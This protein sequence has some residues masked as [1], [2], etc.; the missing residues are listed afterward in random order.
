MMTTGIIAFIG[1]LLVY[2][3]YLVLADSDDFG[4]KRLAKA[5]PAQD[6][7]GELK[8]EQSVSISDDLTAYN[9]CVSIGVDKTGLYL[10]IAGTWDMKDQGRPPIF[11]P[12]SSIK[13]SYRREG[14]M[15]EFC[16]IELKEP[17]DVSIELPFEA[18]EPA[19][20][21]LSGGSA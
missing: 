6:F 3:I 8:P 9:G 19:K 7:A 2:C 5:Y 21:Y 1:A 18:I 4:W 14:D 16:V 17:T 20:A 13:R 10:K 12:W 11:I 15:S